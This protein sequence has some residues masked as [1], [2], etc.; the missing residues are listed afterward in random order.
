MQFIIIDTYHFHHDFFPKDSTKDKSNQGIR[1]V[2]WENWSRDE[3]K[4]AHGIAVSSLGRIEGAHGL[5]VVSLTIGA[6]E[7]GTVDNSIDSLSLSVKSVNVHHDKGRIN[8]GVLE[9]GS[10]KLVGAAVN[11]FAC[12]IVVAIIGAVNGTILN[13]GRSKK[14]EFRRALEG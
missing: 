4:W 9:L 2:C 12:G 11:R 6:F 3:S 1:V 5:A 13:Y 14:R 8:Q 10:Q 7:F